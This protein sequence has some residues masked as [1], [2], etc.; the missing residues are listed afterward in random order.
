MFKIPIKISYHKYVIT[1]LSIIFGYVLLSI[2]MSIE[3][4][5]NRQ[6][7]I[8]QSSPYSLQDDWYTIFLLTILFP[9]I[10]LISIKEYK[11][12][13]IIESVVVRNIYYIFLIGGIIYALISNYINFFIGDFGASWQNYYIANNRNYTFSGWYFIIINIVISII[14]SYNIITIIFISIN[15][16][17]DRTIY[18]TLEILTDIKSELVTIARKIFLSFF[19]FNIILY[20]MGFSNI[21]KSFLGIK[22]DNPTISLVSSW[23]LFTVSFSY[24]AYLYVLPLLLNSKLTAVTKNSNDRISES[25]EILILKYITEFLAIITMIAFILHLLFPDINNSLIKL[26][27][28]MQ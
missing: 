15:I 12:F 14:G 22:H 28:N 5:F 27:L 1:S 19:I 10:S 21:I 9:Y 6:I 11:V 2:F 8:S 18:T 4:T 16:Y 23:V 13:S 3:P 25:I 24:I 20:T 26:L 17:I 7:I